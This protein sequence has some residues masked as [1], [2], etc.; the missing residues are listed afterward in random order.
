MRDIEII[1]QQQIEAVQ[2][3]GQDDPVLR[4]VQKILYSTEVCHELS[5][6]NVALSLP[7]ICRR[8]L[9]FQSRL[10]TKK[11]PSNAYHITRTRTREVY[12]PATSQRISHLVIHLLPCAPTRR[13]DASCPQCDAVPVCAP[14]VSRTTFPFIPL[15]CSS[16][17]SFT[18]ATSSLCHRVH[19]VI[20]SDRIVALS[21]WYLTI[22]LRLVHI[23]VPTCHRR[24]PLEV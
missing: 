16:Q 4:E 11:R 7:V 23:M 8:A 18:A 6:I 3:E 10:S 20:S 15:T 2:A 5:R 22:R 14:D 17:F 1:I 13:Q 24:R 21:C 12:T 9:R 19:N